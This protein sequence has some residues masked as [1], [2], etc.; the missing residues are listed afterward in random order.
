MAADAMK[1][2][3]LA[4]SALAAQPATR[5]QWRTL[6][7]LG[8]ARVLVAVG[9]LLSLAAIG[10]PPVG[11]PG[12][13]APDAMFGLLLDSALYLLL[14][15]L[16]ATAS[17]YVRQQFVLQV[18][19]HLCVDVVLLTVLAVLSGGALHSVVILYLLPLAE[20]SLLLPTVATFFL[21]SIVV[22]A[23]LVD[24]TLRSLAG[25]TSELFQAGLFGAAL[26]GVTGLLR[27][28]AVRLSEQEVLAQARGR[29]LE[30]QLEINRLVI[31]QMAQGVLV[32]DGAC[33]VRANNRAAR[34]M[35][36]L[37]PDY[38]LTGHALDELSAT[39]GLAQAFI[40]WLRQ[41]RSG[42]G[43]SDTL[44]QVRSPPGDMLFPLPELNVRARFV[45]PAAVDTEEFVIFL[46]DTRALE[47]RAQRLKL[48]A[49]GRLT[50]SIA[51]E[52]RNPL[53]AISHAGQLLVEDATDPVQK[54][55]A[56]IVNENTARLNRLVDDV[57][58]VA[59][60]E[61][62]L[63]DVFDLSEF[64]AAW[65]VEF[66]RDRRVEP[67][68]IALQPIPGLEVKFEQ[69][70]LRQILF[71]LVDNALRYASEGAGAV[72][73]VVA[74]ADARDRRPSLWVF[75]DGPG[76]A[77]AA[78]A[79]LFEPFY[80]THA[81]GT[82]LGLYLAREFCVANRADLIYGARRV[83][84]STDRSGFAIRFAPPAADHDREA[85]FL[86]TMPAP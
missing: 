41:G 48:A 4:L 63:G 72:L 68:R 66:A 83:R 57:L 65:I 30:N 47:E 27:L 5:S 59:R 82:G 18:I 40:D 60:R 84:G 74:A 62:P 19:G 53:A 29:V 32:I 37:D 79:A 1:P 17:L 81:R 85:D 52:I 2:G 26:F 61:A 33:R 8:F 50:A 12:R 58:R 86:D 51:H 9:V 35:L 25:A 28:M 56:A 10:A 20:S 73:L 23:L 36:G 16:L 3:P 6:Q 34:R 24:A 15:V 70:H 7:A 78:R 69:A 55:L 13:P 14:S 31:A 77:A 38:H 71:N 49:M 44:A 11:L 64:L 80:T 42:D 39:Q 54:R 76:I 21:C 43:W 75:D 22:I 67:A 45:R 46:E